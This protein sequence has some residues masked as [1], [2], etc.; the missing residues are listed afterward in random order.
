MRNEALCAPL[1]DGEIAVVEHF[2][3]GNRTVSAG[4]D[5]YSQDEN[6]TELYTLLD[7]WVCSLARPSL[8]TLSPMRISGRIGGSCRRHLL[9]VCGMESRTLGRQ[10]RGRIEASCECA[11]AW[12]EI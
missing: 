8:A 4:A 12:L 9:R 1:S 6:S 3:S 10:L 2:K 5:L 7:G 11:R